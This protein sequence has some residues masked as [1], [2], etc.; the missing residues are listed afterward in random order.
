MEA[1]RMKFSDEKKKA[2][3]L[4]ILDKISQGTTN[5]SK[6]TSEAFEANQN[7]I[8]AYINQL[9]EDNIIRRVK[10]G[11]YELVQQEY[12]YD[13]KRSEGDLDTDTFAFNAY[14]KQHI[15][16]LEQNVKAIWEYTF[17][18]MMNNV[19]DHSGAEHVRIQVKQDYLNT[20]VKIADD[21]VGIFEKIKNYFNLE[22]L[23]E[24]I[25]ELFKG[26]LT[27]DSENH[28]GEGIFFS[29]KLMDYFLIISS[30]RTFTN[31]KF[32]DS[33]IMDSASEKSAGTCVIMTLA[34]FTH[35]QSFEVFDLYF[36]VHGGFTKTRIPLKNIFDSSPVSRSQAKRVCHRLDKFKEV[37]LDFEGVEWMGQGFAHQIFVIFCKEHPDIEIIVENMNESVEKMYHHVKK[38]DAN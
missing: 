13:L 9:V 22:S 23:D 35:K 1:D 26:K 29:S 6:C 18:E 5:I 30:E 19:M 33:E 17:S 12:V 8:H 32:D 14:F 37:V 36:N 38:T 31:N 20:T 24:A 34:N 7:T 3:K 25:C 10:R 2:I 27:T 11:V 21:G 28:S 15:A 16:D 4:Y